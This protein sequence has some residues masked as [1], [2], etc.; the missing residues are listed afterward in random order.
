MK[1]STLLF[2]IAFIA[3]HAI[4][5]VAQPFLGLN[6]GATI[7]TDSRLSDNISSGTMSYN[8]GGVISGSIGEDFGVS[9]IELE[10]GYRNYDVD[11]HSADG[12]SDIL[13]GTVSVVNYM[14]NGYLTLPFFY[15][16]KP[17]VMIGVGLA[18]M[19]SGE[20]KR[21]SLE[22]TQIIDPATNTQ[23]VYQTGLGVSYDVSDRVALDA[24][25]RYMGSSDFDLNGTKTGY[26]SHNLLLGCRYYF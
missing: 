5:A 9:R 11:R 2:V 23:Y 12:N 19:Q 1:S 3:S 17:F 21:L 22:G 25:Y 13:N 16:V 7:T 8:T 15:P 24:G 20:L 6:V 18:T 26:G 10:I 14:A 4:T